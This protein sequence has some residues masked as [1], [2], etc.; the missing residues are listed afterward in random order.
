[1]PTTDIPQAL[2]NEYALTRP[3]KGGPVFV[4]PQY[5][6]FRINFS[7]LTRRQAETLLAHKWPG[8]CRVEAPAK[9]PELPTQAAPESPAEATETT[10]ESAPVE[11]HFRRK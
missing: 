4:F 6:G 1:M 5:G 3:L 11:R 9:A 10:D 7:T 8:I 2:R